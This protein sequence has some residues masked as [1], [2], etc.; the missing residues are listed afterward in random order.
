MEH[1][2]KVYMAP[3]QG[4][5][6]APFR[7][8]F[9]KHFGGVEAYYTPFVRWEHD[10]MRRKDLRE[11]LPEN[12]SVGMLVP[13]ILAGSLEEAELLLAQILPLGYRRIDLNMGCAFPAVA[14]KMKGCGILPFPERVGEVLQVVERHP[15]VS[16]SV[17]MRLGYEETNEC[18]FLLPLLNGVKLACVTVHARTGK[19][20]YKGECDRDAFR[21]FADACGHPV[22]YNGDIA[23]PEDCERLA[24][25][26]PELHGVMI[27]RGLLAAPWLA[28]EYRAGKTWGGAERYARM[29]LFHADL[30]NHY[31][32][33]LEG[34]EKQL[35]MKMKAFWEYLLPDA[36]RKLHKKIHKAQKTADY[37]DAVSRLLSG[38]E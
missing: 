21:R 4:V 13:Q 3:M 18:M 27:G 35:L 14:K 12:N 29:R 2:L 31:A 32:Q 20:Q 34:G 22:V 38:E 28:A 11:L 15:E 1:R 26:M 5:T 9:D 19:Q 23:T 33:T 37:T 30:F 7:N 25:C 24:G 36:D 16:F 10:G 6:E 17:K 8:L